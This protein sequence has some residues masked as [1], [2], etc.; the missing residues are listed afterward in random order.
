MCAQSID[1]VIDDMV[2]KIVE[3]F[4]P[5]KIILFGSCARGETT[6]DSD[7]DILIVIPVKHSTRQMANEIDLSLADRT[8]PLDLLVVT[9]EQ[10]DHQ[11]NIVGTTIHEAVREGRTLYDRAH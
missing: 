8:V 3:R 11:K 2:R 5:D 1:M 9:P 7:I 6:K 10:Y 4:H